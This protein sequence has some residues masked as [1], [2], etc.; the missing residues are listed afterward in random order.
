[1][2]FSKSFEYTYE[3]FIQQGADK[4]QSKPGDFARGGAPDGSGGTIKSQ[5]DL[6]RIVEVQPSS[7]S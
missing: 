5:K 3:T 2:R 7:R 1:M 4:G 6:P